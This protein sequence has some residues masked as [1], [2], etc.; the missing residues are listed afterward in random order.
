MTRPAPVSR[1]ALADGAGLAAQTQAL[2]AEIARRLG[3]SGENLAALEA[4]VCRQLPWRLRRVWRGLVRAEPMM[5]HPTLA[6]TLD[7]ARLGRDMAA[8]A[9]H[10]GRI[11]H[12]RRRVNFWLGMLGGIAFNLLVLAGLLLAVLAWRAA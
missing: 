1:A 11:D 3:L 2:R 12:K 9:R 4:P 5:A 8:I 6:L 7:Q 10:L